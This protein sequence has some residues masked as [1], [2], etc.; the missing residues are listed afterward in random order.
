MHGPGKRPVEERETVCLGTG[1]GTGDP[2]MFAIDT[3][4]GIDRAALER[5][6]GRGPGAVDVAEL[7]VAWAQVEHAPVLEAE[8]HL[9]VAHAPL[10]LTPE[11]RRCPPAHSRAA[12]TLQAPHTVTGRP[13]SDSS[14]R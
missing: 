14:R 10:T 2:T 1:R 11:K 12:R 8:R 13:P 3:D 7:R 9:A 5:V 6:H 4:H